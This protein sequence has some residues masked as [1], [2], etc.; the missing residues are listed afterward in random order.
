MAGTA[1]AVLSSV[2]THRKHRMHGMHRAKAVPLAQLQ[3]QVTMRVRGVTISTSPSATAQLPLAPASDSDS[4]A[5]ERLDIAATLSEGRAQ[6]CERK[7]A[8]AAEAGVHSSS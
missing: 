8:C 7:R 2:S 5:I 4:E 3:H 1:N 6:R